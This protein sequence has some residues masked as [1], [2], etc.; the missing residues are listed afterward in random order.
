MEKYILGE[1]LNG[2]TFLQGYK[3][4][5]YLYVFLGINGHQGIDLSRADGD[6]IPAYYSGTIIYIQNDAIVYLTDPDE[7]KLCLEITI[8]HGKNYRFKVGDRIEKGQIIC[9]QSTS[10]PSIGWGEEDFDRI[11]WSHE[12]LAIRKAKRVDAK[13]QQ[14]LIWNWRDFS[15]INYVILNE[16]NGMDGFINPNDYNH[17]LIYHFAK[18][19]DRKEDSKVDYAKGNNPGNVRSIGGSFITFKTYDEGFLYLM[20]YIERAITG[21]HA[22]YLKYGHRMT[23]LEFFKTYAPKEDG[24]DPVKYAQ[25]VVQWIGLKGIDQ[26]MSDFLL[27]EIQYLQKYYNLSSG[28]VPHIK[29]KTTSVEQEKVEDLRV[30]MNPLTRM[31]LYLFNK[32]FRQ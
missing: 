30:A 4:N 26:P 22:A 28:L 24:N 8:A 14:K 2:L 19:I 18:A 25:D 29:E 15:P 23:V 20:N 9:D 17:R 32:Y 27:T 11:A 12:H 1:K 10:G 7:N 5:P 31:V 21:R 3:D 6:P 16:D 13:V